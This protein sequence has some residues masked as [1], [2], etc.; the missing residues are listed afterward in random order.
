MVE[1]AF[2]PLCSLISVYRR[3]DTSLLCADL[4]CGLMPL[5]STTFAAERTAQQRESKDADV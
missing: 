3:E 1:V 5:R 2:T 4:Y